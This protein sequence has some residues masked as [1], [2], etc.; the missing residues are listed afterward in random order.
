M[1]SHIVVSCVSKE[2]PPQCSSQNTSATVSTEEN[3]EGNRF[4]EEIPRLSNIKSALKKVIADRSPM[5]VSSTCEL[6]SPSEVKLLN[7]KKTYRCKVCNKTFCNKSNRN[8][9]WKSTHRAVDSLLTAEQ[10]KST[11]TKIK[12]LTDATHN[13]NHKLHSCLHRHVIT[14]T[15]SGIKNSYFKYSLYTKSVST[16]HLCQQKFINVPNV[17]TNLLRKNNKKFKCKQCL[18]T[19]KSNGNLT[20]NINNMH[21]QRDPFKYTLFRKTFRFKS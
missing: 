19:L 16:C 7:N 6:S 12:Q 11:L 21:N 20:K 9:H 10:V 5:L 3:I 2:I 15:F 14:K 1:I 13:D 17:K 8:D 18:F 4:I